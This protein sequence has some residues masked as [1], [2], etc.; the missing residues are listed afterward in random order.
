MNY[1]SLLANV[2]RHRKL[3][4]VLVW[5]PWWPHSME[6]NRRRCDCS[7][8]N[9]A[10][11]V[12]CIRL[13]H[14]CLASVELIWKDNR[15]LKQYIDQLNDELLTLFENFAPHSSINMSRDIATNGSLPVPVSRDTSAPDRSF[16]K[17]RTIPELIYTVGGDGAT[18]EEGK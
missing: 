14:E 4:S 18:W 10:S 15:F 2:A 8:L 16:W 13:Y 5:Y 9:K 12:T 6:Q 11:K 1:G 7:C 3:P 17:L